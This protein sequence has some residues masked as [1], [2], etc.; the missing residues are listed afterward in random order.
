[1]AEEC[2]DDAEFDALLRRALQRHRL[3]ADF[4]RWVVRAIQA[5]RRWRDQTPPR[6]EPACPPRRRPPRRRG[7][8][9]ADR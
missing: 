9:D 7:H 8:D 3:R 6:N 2:R 5:D 4:A 1:M